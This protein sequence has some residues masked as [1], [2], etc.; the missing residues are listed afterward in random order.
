MTINASGL[1]QWTPTAPG[2]VAVTVKA[3]NSAGNDTQ[4]FTLTVQQE[5]H[6]TSSPGT[7]TEVGMLYTYDVNAVGYPEPTFSLLAGPPGMQINATTGVITWTPT[8]S[9][10]SVRHSEGSKQCWGN[11]SGFTIDVHDIQQLTNV[12]FMP[13]IFASGQ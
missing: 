13:T 3:S 6:I 9:G 11:H 10:Q 8:A 7:Y 1:I 4:S 5:P 2:M 12:I